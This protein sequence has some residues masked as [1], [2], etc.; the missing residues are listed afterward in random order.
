MVNFITP[1]QAAELRSLYEQLPAAVA[2]AAAEFKTE[3]PL[4]IWDEAAQARFVEED[5][6]VGEIFR[7]IRELQGG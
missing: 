4:H 1:E 5:R 2:R 7:R 6:K 3:P